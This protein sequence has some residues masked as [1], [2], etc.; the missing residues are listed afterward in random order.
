MKFRKISIF[1]AT[2]LGA[3]IALTSC[4]KNDGPMTNRVT[5]NDAISTIIDP[6]GSQSTF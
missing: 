6:S 4:T 3:I 2:F 1:L 5:I